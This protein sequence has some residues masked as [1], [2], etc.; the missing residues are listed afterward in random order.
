MSYLEEYLVIWSSL[1]GQTLTRE[2]LARGTSLHGL[3]VG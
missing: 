2:G 1:T 3:G